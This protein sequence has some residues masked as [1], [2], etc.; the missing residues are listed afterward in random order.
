MTS[1]NPVEFLYLNPECQA[2]QG[3]VTVD[4]A[5][6]LYVNG[7]TT[8]LNTTMSNLPPLF[9]ADT[10]ITAN[11]SSIDVSNLN[12]AI[13]LAMLNM[14]ASEDDVS[15]VSKYLPTIY[16]DVI[17]QNNGKF[18]IL[19]PTFLL[20]Q[21]NLQIND[22]V[23]LQDSQKNEYK[24]R[25]MDIPAASLQ[26]SFF[27]NTAGMQNAQL[28]VNDTYKLIGIN[29]YDADRLARINYVR[30][31]S[32][33][34]TSL[35]TID[36]RFNPDMYR[37]LYPETLSLSDPHVYLDYVAHSNQG[38]FRF[39]NY[40]ELLNSHNA[41]VS[42]LQVF[43]KLLV[44]GKAML[45]DDLVAYSNVSINN[46]IV[47]HGS[48]LIGSNIDIYGS[49][50]MRNSLLLTGGAFVDRCEISSN[51]VVNNNAII[52]GSMS[53][54]GNFYNSRIGLGDANL[55]MTSNDGIDIVHAQ[56]YNDNSDVRIKT[57]I[58]NVNDPLA[59]LNRIDIKQF[60]Y[61]YGEPS[62]DDRDTY[63]CIAQQVEEVDPDLVYTTCG[64]IS[65][66]MKEVHIHNDIMTCRS[67]MRQQ[68]VC[69][70]SYKL[71]SNTYRTA[72][73]IK[74]IAVP[75]FGVF[76]IEPSLTSGSYM[77]Y[78]AFTSEL[79]NVDYKQ[80]FVLAIG[81]IGQLSDRINKIE[82]RM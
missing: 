23:L 74:I 29:V 81:A 65:D 39:A 37:V 57:N 66:I 73:F 55:Y 5:I 61:K 70:T 12:K 34:N 48:G 45:Y 62:K 53:V 36:T 47:V 80:L 2:Y 20:S 69:G 21:S 52:Y 10:F 18:T 26:H 50:R 4:D 32:T 9:D 24:L 17:Y 51:I 54:K 14:G 35:Y 1:F 64:Y 38:D 15:S 30:S 8:G 31:I 49:S 13:K 41:G 40:R 76:K 3:V 67:D 11:S 19:D 7:G 28:I 46:E 59:I 71:I 44:T 58:R 16:K 25:V 60:N 78:G 72:H 43:E 82:K 6:N 42:N 68:L 63:G 22:D 77:L 33:S 79:K 56:N 75:K 27:V